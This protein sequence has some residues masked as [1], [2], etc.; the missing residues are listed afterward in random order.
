MF[1]CIVY[2][3]DGSE[4]ARK[5]LAY[6]RD[7]T[8]LHKAKL[9][10]VHAYSSVS[11]LLGYKEY[12]SIV[13]RRIAHG[14]EIVGEAVK[15]LESAGLTVEIELLEGP[16]A[17]AILRVAE[18][19]EADLIIVGARGS[20]SLRGLLLGSVSQKVIQHAT[21]PVLVVR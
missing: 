7:L 9:F 1:K 16:M 13:A 10:V 5:A 4:H 3:T 8:K 17:E 12:S 19:R 14:E 18:T 11:D 20:S 15:E 6:A 2:A 21:C